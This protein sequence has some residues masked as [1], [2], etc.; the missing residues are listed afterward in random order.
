MEAEEDTQAFGNGPH[1]LA[2][3]HGTANIFGHVQTAEEG[4]FW[5]ATGAVEAATFAV[6][7]Q[8]ANSGSRP[9]AIADTVNMRAWG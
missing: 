8:L 2:W 3:G 1:E 9:P 5:G 7:N 4:A 6:Q